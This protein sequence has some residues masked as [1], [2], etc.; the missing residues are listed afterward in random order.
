M[1]YL[2]AS[3]P[4]VLFAA[5]WFFGAFN[6][7][8]PK[9]APS[10]KPSAS[11]SPQNHEAAKPV[12]STDPAQRVDTAPHHPPGKNAADF[13]KQAYGLYKA[14]NLTDEEKQML[15]DR[16]GKWDKEKAKALFEKIQPV[17]EMMRQAEDTAYA[18][19]GIQ[20][21]TFSDRFPQLVPATDLSRLM[22]WNAAYEF[23]STPAQALSD[24][25]IQTQLGNSVG[26]D[27]II[28]LI[29]NSATSALAIDTL[30][31][32]AAY[33]SSETYSQA[34]AMI[35][36]SDWLKNLSSAMNL[37]SKVVNET[38]DSL[39]QGKM[40]PS[41]P[42]FANYQQLPSA[43]MVAQMRWVADVETDFSQKAQLPDAEF[44]SWWK[45]IQ[46][47]ISGKPVAQDTLPIL[48]TIRTRI[49]YSGVQTTMLQAGLSILQNGDSALA[50][51]P[52]PTTKQPFTLVPTA[53]GF[54][55][56]STFQYHGKP[57]TMPF[58]TPKP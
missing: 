54:E 23:P 33:I 27:A 11:A 7:P 50:T 4:F 40:N 28:G 31:S 13:Y 51:Y 12:T 53:D 29:V 39:E 22:T 9:P 25:R 42:L 57:V 37:E 49:L 19:W 20:F 46:Q 10:P 17:V 14:L 5:L 41:N 6:Q 26:N 34:L 30:R 45:G 1:L 55:L 56:Q 2:L 3:L 38:A 32:N 36:D 58:S 21:K 15:R 18:D 16:N 52:D 35:Q 8:S 47:A 43:E 48:S 24:L 44:E